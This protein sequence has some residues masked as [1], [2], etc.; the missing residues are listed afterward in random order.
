M[1][2]I[3]EYL[4]G[5]VNTVIPAVDTAFHNWGR[6]NIDCYCFDIATKQPIP[7]WHMYDQSTNGTYGIIG[8]NFG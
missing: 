6:S 3:D 2:T 8:F 1:Y 7:Q 5:F 4:L